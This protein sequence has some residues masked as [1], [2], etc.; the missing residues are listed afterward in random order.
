MASIDHN[1]VHRDHNIQ[2]DADVHSHFG[3]GEHGRSGDDGG[4]DDDDDDDD[5]EDIYRGPPVRARS[6]SPSTISTVSSQS[7]FGGRLGAIAAVVDL[8]ISRWARG[9]SSGSSTS[10][11]SSSSSSSVSSRSQRGRLRRR[12]SATTL[13]SVHSERD[14]AA[15][16][17]R[18]KAREESR[19]IPRRF[20]LYAPPQPKRVKTGSKDQRVNQTS[21]LPPLLPQLEAALKMATRA[22]R[23]QT[24]RPLEKA[25]SKRPMM[26]QDYMIPSAGESSTSTALQPT[27]AKAW[28]LDVASPTWEDMRTLGKATIDTQEGAKALDVSG[29]GGLVG[30]AHVYLVVF[31]EGICS[32][33]LTASETASCN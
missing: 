18:L 14:I 6:V 29:Q 31:D 8:A 4:G 20:T 21:S 11:S 12:R 16:I 22:R 17:S 19:K 28:Y 7:L 15:H 26:H 24:R 25:R 30:E 10:S 1:D 3:D 13:R 5:E 33:T 2:G 23:N 32:S 9:N 27:K